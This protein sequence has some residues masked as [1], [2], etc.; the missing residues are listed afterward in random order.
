MKRVRLIISGDVV[1]VG[2]RAWVVRRAQGLG[3]TGWVKNREDGAVEIVAEGKKEKL[4]E[5]IKYCKHGPD[6]AWVERVEITWLRETG[7]FFNFTVV[8]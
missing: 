7:E 8:Y 1:G 4:D 5:L 6:V 2:Y 3:L